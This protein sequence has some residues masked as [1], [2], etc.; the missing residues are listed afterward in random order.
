MTVSYTHLD[1]YK[2]QHPG[3]GIRHRAAGPRDGGSAGAGDLPA[4][5]RRSRRRHPA[6]R[7]CTVMEAFLYEL[8]KSAQ[9]NMTFEEVLLLISA[10]AVSMYGRRK[11]K[12]LPFLY[13]IFL[14]VYITLLR[15]SPG[16][17]EE[18]QLYLQLWANAGTLAGNVWNVLLYLPL[19][20]IHISHRCC[21]HPH[22]HR[23]PRG[24]GSRRL[25]PGWHYNPGTSQRHRY[26]D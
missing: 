18:I 9:G 17:R 13:S 21:V 25:Y 2:R 6:E 26:G 11:W 8:S 19:S 22:L 10:G 4:V 15:R 23:A 14:I 7:V 12:T 16:Y 1:V 20:L 5:C 24:F 3:A